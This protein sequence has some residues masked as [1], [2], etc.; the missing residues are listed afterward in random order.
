MF[1]SSDQS[2]ETNGKFD[3]LKSSL[4]R[5]TALYLESAK[6]TATEKLT[7]L[8]SA[9]VVFVVGFILV[10]FAVTFAAV[11]LLELLEMALSPIA[12][13]GILAGFFLIVA[14]LFFLLRKPLVIN[15]M[16]RFMSRLIMDIGNDRIKEHE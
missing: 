4:K 5:L 3:A 7:L 6:L 1:H 15:P 9:A 13:S 8:L 2:T 16:A 12:A 10:A 14:V 11:T